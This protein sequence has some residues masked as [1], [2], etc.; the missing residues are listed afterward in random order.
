[1]KK[2]VVA[3]ILALSVFATSLTACGEVSPQ[4]DEYVAVCVDPNTEQRLED[5]ACEQGDSDFLT[6]AVLWYMLANSNHS[7]PAVGSHVTKSHFKTS[8]P[9][10]A[11]VRTGL[12]TKGGTSVKTYVDKKYGSTTK[13]NDGSQYKKDNKGYKPYKPGGSSKRR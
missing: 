5:D 2:I 12:P 9:K 7:Y 8:K 11:H 13:K 4:Q 1:M 10:N 3:W 6:Y